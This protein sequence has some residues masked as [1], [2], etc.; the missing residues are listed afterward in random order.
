M[1]KI[2]NKEVKFYQQ[3]KQSHSEYKKAEPFPHCVID[4]LINEKLLKQVSSEFKINKSDSINFD[5]PNE[6]KI[7]SIGWENFGY[8]SKKLIKYLNSKHFVD[9]LE[10]LTGING[11]IPDE[12]LEGGGFH[13][14][15]RGGF[16]KIH[17]DF[18]K[19]SVSN[20]DRRL[21]VLLFINEE[22]SQE[23]RGDFEMWSRDAKTCVKK[24]S[25]IFNRMVIFSTTD[26]SFH[27]HPDPLDC[28]EGIFRRSIALYYYTV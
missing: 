6:K 26:Y 9:F 20:F 11:L 1:E 13:E 28:P 4:N 8:Q 19:H 15:E 27:G 12:T 7:A 2:I 18:N 16:L 10:K 23:W 22:W 14:I 3:V 21:N 24:I 25:P 17:A 5:N